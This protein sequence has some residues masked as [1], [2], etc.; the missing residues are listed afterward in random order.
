M[1]ENRRNPAATDF[2]LLI[3]NED[4]SAL[5]LNPNQVGN[6]EIQLLKES[7]SI[8]PTG[9]FLDGTD[10]RSP[11]Y[12]L[13]CRHFESAIN[14]NTSS[15]KLDI[16]LENCKI[17]DKE[18]VV[19]WISGVNRT[20]APRALKLWLQ[21]C[22]QG[23]TINVDRVQTTWETRL[24]PDEENFWSTYPMHENLGSL[25]STKT[26]KWAVTIKSNLSCNPKIK[27][28]ILLRNAKV[29]GLRSDF[30]R[31]MMQHAELINEKLCANSFYSASVIIDELLYPL[32]EVIN[33]KD[34]ARYCDMESNSQ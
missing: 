15:D 8:I 31:S 13:E 5:F 33:M 34:A 25:I 19:K 4:R 22:R 9:I 29:F 26:R 23:L 16:F 2:L 6:N 17:T 14:R 27:S 30:F 24:S 28:M 7:Y 1:V 12:L 10:Q 11:D 21:K 3:K 32:A 18:L 20:V